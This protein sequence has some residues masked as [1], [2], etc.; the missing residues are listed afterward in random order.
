MKGKIADINELRNQSRAPDGD[1]VLESMNIKEIVD[2]YPDKII[3]VIDRKKDV[4]IIMD[5]CRI[6]FKKVRSK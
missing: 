1:Y 3:D 5:T 4:V 2:K 6:V